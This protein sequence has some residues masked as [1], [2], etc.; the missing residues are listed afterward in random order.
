MRTFFWICLALLIPGMLARFDAGG[1][2]VLATDLILPVFC[3]V[4]LIQ[5]IVIER[6]FP[7]N[8][9][10]GA[11]FFFVSIL[12]A[13]WLLGAWDLDL[14][15]KF[16][17][18]AYLVRLVEFLIFGW[19]ATDL[20]QK[21]PSVRGTQGEKSSFYSKFFTISAVVIF[22]G[23]VQFFIVPDISTFST[24]GGL[25]P[26]SGR[27]LGTWLD[28]NYL[29]GFLGFLIPVVLGEWYRRKNPKLLALAGIAI[30]A[31]FFTFS[32]SGLL[33][34]GIGLG[35]FFLLKD[36]KILIIAALIATTGIAASPRAQQRIGELVGTTRSIILRDTDE[37]DP[38]ANLRITN[39]K[40][41]FELFEKNPIVGTGFGT[42]RWA[43]AEEGIVD[44]NYFS[45]GFLALLVHASFVNSLFFPLI[46]LPVVAVAGV[47]ELKN[48]T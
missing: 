2:G 44:E 32:R 5:K 47:L 22:L 14:K 6:N 16:L 11:G 23:F 9:W 42:Y 25:D 24:E 1:A 8:R 28:P 20:F 39:W 15:S 40:K 30:F 19:A 7:K 38:T 31:L 36:W 45:A 29:A 27:L 26:H 3:T 4:W 33:A 35:F 46:F 34:T 12:F 13:T 18:A 41:S 48:E 10:I 17:S 21:S 43:A 37:V